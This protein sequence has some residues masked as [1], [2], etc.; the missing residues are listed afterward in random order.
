[1]RRKTVEKPGRRQPA[2]FGILVLLWLTCGLVG[3]AQDAPQPRE[4]IPAASAPELVHPAG[5][6]LHLGDKIEIR[7]F[8]QPELNQETIIKPDGRISLQLIGEVNAVGLTTGEL[9]RRLTELYADILVDPVISVILKEYVKPRVFISG[10]VTRPGPYELRQGETLAQALALA[11][12][13][14]PRAH[15]KM[16]I[17]ARPMGEGQLRVTVIDAT[18]LFGRHPDPELNLA[19]KD[20]DLIYVPESKLSRLSKIL[21]AL[22]IQTFGLFTDPFRR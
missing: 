18:K 8:Y 3:W 7:F 14:T 4:G 13:F 17:H 2:R 20:G 12:G 11:G 16:V 15:R 21:S 19:L 5:Y 1:M 9:E 6:R 10:E 22:R